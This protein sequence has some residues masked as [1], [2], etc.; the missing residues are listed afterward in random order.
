MSAPLRILTALTYYRPHWT[1][2]TVYAQ[3]IAEGLAAR[4][5]E[6]TVLCAAHDR[7]LPRRERVDGVDVV[8]APTIGRLSRAA[9]APSLLP[10]ARRLLADADV[11][12]VHSPMP[13]MGPLVALAQRAGV[14]SIVIHQGDVVMPRGA[15]NRAIQGAMHLTSVSAVRRAD[16][17]V[18]HSLDYAAHSRLLA[19][20][21][22][23]VFG[24][25]PPARI[26]EPDPGAVAAWRTEL[27]LDD[28]GV[29]GFAGRFVEEKGFDRLL[30]ALPELRRLRPDVHL[31]F[32]GEVDVGYERFQERCGSLL[33]AAGSDLTSVGLL[34]DRQRLADFYAM[35]DVFVLPSRTDCFAGVQLE[36]LLC[37][38]PLVTADIPGARDVVA[39]TGLGRIVDAGDPVALAAA[40][41]AELDDPRS[42][43]RAAALAHY[44]PELALDRYE[45]LGAAAVAR[46]PPAVPARPPARSTPDPRWHL[47]DAARATVDRLLANE[48]DMAYRRRVPR[49]L[50]L[51]ELGPGQRVLDAGCGMGVLTLALRALGATG[52]VAGDRVVER[53]QWARRE[54]VDAPLLS[55][56]LERLP[57]PDGTFDRVL[58][59]EVLEHLQDDGRGLVELRRVMAPGAVLA[60]SVP[61][62]LYPGTWDPIGRVRD[63]LGAP[64]MRSTGPITGQWSGHERLYLP[65]ELERV[66]RRAG[67]LVDTVEQ[68]TAHAVPLNHLLVYSVGKPLIE[69][70]LLPRRL[71]RSVDRF[72]GADHPASGSNPVEL[73]RRALRRRD[74]R[75]DRPGSGEVRFVQ[76]V[77]RA[78]TPG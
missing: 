41:A 61:H 23:P 19:E 57:F 46:R 32:A 60:L 75:N 9:V 73:V 31:L 15:A 68:Q 50:E 72:H 3:N 74:A 21:A 70:G 28:K 36:A 71:L 56:D 39:T 27:G 54:Q 77:A 12:H 33:E 20:R 43:D 78:V 40:I 29:V 59:A 66:L 35:C 63:A 10:T 2:L 13:E 18:T 38:T 55:F 5:H 8:R 11:L 26:P 25:A 67:F 48:T 65:H 1:G 16:V 51:L 42:F 34:L 24:V 69:H 49:L 6:V 52:V 53:L 14:P 4:G 62:A 17:V 30:A 44:D 76:L 64:P 45:E 47:D 7:S 37:G 58:L 22:G